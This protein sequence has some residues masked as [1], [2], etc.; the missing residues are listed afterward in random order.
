M[1]NQ[2]FLSYILFPIKRNSK[3]PEVTERQYL[4][5]GCVHSWVRW[6]HTWPSWVWGVSGPLWVPSRSVSSCGLSWGPSGTDGP[7]NEPAP[8]AETLHTHPR[9]CSASGCNSCIHT[10]QMK[11]NVRKKNNRQPKRNT[12]CDMV[13]HVFLLK[14]YSLNFLLWI[15][16]RLAGQVTGEVVCWSA[17]SSL[18]VSSSTSFTIWFVTLISDWSSSS[19]VRLPASS[20]HK[21]QIKY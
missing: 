14:S 15:L 9:L 6:W 1:S 11:T 3:S 7:G 4:W 20:W 16:G 13:N 10:F 21:T 17:V 5:T 18:S 8:L 19:S 12:S 2:D